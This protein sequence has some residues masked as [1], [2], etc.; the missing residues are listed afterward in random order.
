MAIDDIVERKN[1]RSCMEAFQILE[2]KLFMKGNH[3]GFEVWS[4]KAPSAS[5][6]LPVHVLPWVSISIFIFYLPLY[7]H[8]CAHNADNKFTNYSFEFLVNHSIRNKV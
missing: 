7:T 3:G 2:V 4:L 1:P 6:R 5:A 8:A